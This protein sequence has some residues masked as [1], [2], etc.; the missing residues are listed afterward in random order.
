M[1]SHPP[2]LPLA[3]VFVFIPC[4]LLFIRCF[5]DKKFRE[6]LKIGASSYLLILLLFCPLVIFLPL[7]FIAA[8]MLEV[9]G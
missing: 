3:L 4:V 8:V 7:V 2:L 6:E 9:R 5:F 1:N